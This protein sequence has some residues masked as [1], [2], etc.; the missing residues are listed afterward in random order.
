MISYVSK[1]LSENIAW[2]LASLSQIAAN[3]LRSNRKEH[4]FIVRKIKILQVKKIK[5]RQFK[6]QKWQ[7]NSYKKKIH[8]LHYL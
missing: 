3:N 5:I 8:F 2:S 7:N 6:L 1:K 4:G